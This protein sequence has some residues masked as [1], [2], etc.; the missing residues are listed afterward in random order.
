MYPRALLDDDVKSAG[1][2]KVFQALESGLDDAWEVFDP[3]GW[4]R[5]DPGQ[6]AGDGEIDFVLAHPDH[7]IV[8]WR[9]RAAIW[10]A[11]TAS[12]CGAVMEAGSVRAIRPR[13]RW[14]T[15]TRWS[16]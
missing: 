13:R 15:A 10:S 2:T 3:V 7:G 8:A 16:A 14:I 11:V 1:E 6:G 4:V 5:R 12:G 9:S